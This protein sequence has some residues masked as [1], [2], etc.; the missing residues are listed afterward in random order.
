MAP[1]SGGQHGTNNV[2]MSTADD[3]YMQ[4]TYY[5]RFG[6]NQSSLIES[7]RKVE[8]GQQQL[9]KQHQV[10]INTATT[11]NSP[12]LGQAQ[13]PRD[14]QHHHGTNRNYS[15]YYPEEYRNYSHEGGHAVQ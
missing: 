2:L 7:L 12:Y 11:S 14:S 5:Q 4:R 9:G 10:V 1:S 8:P 15:Q 13:I 6:N 3:P